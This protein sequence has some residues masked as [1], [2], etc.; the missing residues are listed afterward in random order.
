MMT[1]IDIEEWEERAAI[2][3]FDGGMSRFEAETKAAEMR[4]RQ[5]WEFV[6]A[7]RER[8]TAGDGA[9]ARQVAG[10]QRKDNLPR[11][12][13]QQAQEERSVPQRDAQA[14]W[15]RGVLPPLRME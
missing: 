12:Q 8:D 15:D 14:G 2:M 11:V 1:D 7:I 9:G 4:G 5:R 3:E 13:R 6:S 10:Q